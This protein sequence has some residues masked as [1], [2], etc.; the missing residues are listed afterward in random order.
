MTKNVFIIA[1]LSLY[2][3]IF[4][5][6]DGL[7]QRDISSDAE[8]NQE[9][10]DKAMEEYQEAI[11]SV[12]VGETVSIPLSQMGQRGLQNPFTVALSVPS[13]S[14]IDSVLYQ[15]AIDMSS[16]DVAQTI[17]GVRLAEERGVM[18]QFKR[19]L[20]NFV[21]GKSIHESAMKQFQLYE[22]TINAKFNALNAAA[23]LARQSSLLI[24]PDGSKYIDKD[25]FEKNMDLVTDSQEYADVS[26]FL[27]DADTLLK[28]VSKKNI[29]EYQQVTVLRRAVNA[30]KAKPTYRLLFLQ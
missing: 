9:A 10:I 1:L 23:N 15:P 7:T 25:V 17:Q 4:A 8:V 22:K 16:E 29:T 24:A 30:L 6:R 28:E 14:I 2:M 13:S 21:Y 11:Q 12:P 5:G 27:S 19:W 26:I 18:S 20:N 3:P